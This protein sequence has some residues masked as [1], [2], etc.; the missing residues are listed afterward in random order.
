M[1]KKKNDDD[2][3]DDGKYHTGEGGSGSGDGG[4]DGGDGGDGS[5]TSS[6][7]LLRTL[8]HSS[9]FVLVLALERRYVLPWIQ[10][11][12]VV[13]WGSAVL[14]AVLWLLLAGIAARTFEV[15]RD[16]L[17]TNDSY[18]FLFFTFLTRLPPSLLS[19]F[20][21]KNNHY[22]HHQSIHPSINSNTTLQTRLAAMSPRPWPFRAAL[23]ARL[24]CS[25]IWWAWNGCCGRWR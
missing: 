19:K 24:S 14:V 25:A 5:K 18:S 2:E 8:G 1:T 22:T 21:H 6:L 17:K 23:L 11:W 12:L 3:Y 7:F 16:F 15:R 9:A 20:N 13:P 4:D 10:P